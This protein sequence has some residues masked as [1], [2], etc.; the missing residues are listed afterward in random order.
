LISEINGLKK[1]LK[2]LEYL[3]KEVKKMEM[4][5]ID[6]KAVVEDVMKKEIE[7]NKEEI[8]MLRRRL[9]ELETGVPQSFHQEDVLVS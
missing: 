7:K 9:N 6:K 1:E 8:T 3:E 5:K 2:Y 4:N